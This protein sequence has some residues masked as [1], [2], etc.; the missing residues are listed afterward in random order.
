MTVWNTRRRPGPASGPT[1]RSDAQGDVH[2]IGP[3]ARSGSLHLL[4]ASLVAVWLATALVSALDGGS[5]GAAMLVQAGVHDA[6]LRA[7]LLWGGVAL[8]AA[9]GVALAFAPLRAAATLAFAATALM[10]VISTVLIPGAWLD[11]LGPLLKNLPILAALRVLR[12]S[13]P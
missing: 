2:E 7:L 12:R 4:R 6:A 3:K 11:P 5:R 1:L 13:A 9:L 10:T 8:D